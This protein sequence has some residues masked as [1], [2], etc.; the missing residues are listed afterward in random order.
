MKKAR[1]IFLL[2]VILSMA[3]SCG[4]DP[5]PTAMATETPPVATATEETTTTSPL[6]TPAAPGAQSPL[7]TPPMELPEDYTPAP[8]C[9]AVSGVL[10]RGDPPQPVNRGILYLGQVVTQ[11]DGAPVMASLNKQLAP[12][13]G[14]GP[15]GEFVFID[16]PEGRYALVLDV[17][18]S[19]I[20][21]RNPSDGGDLLVNVEAGEVVDLGKLVYSDMPSLP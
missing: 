7:P 14:I 4:Q 20:V 9:G 6:P 8:G 13:S 16:V 15:G 10:L 5:Q 19:T 2:L 1:L 17:I 18:A 21:L 3:A 11:E 12:A